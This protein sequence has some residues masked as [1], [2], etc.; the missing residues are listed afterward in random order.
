[1]FL[2]E[3]VKAEQL[4]RVQTENKLT[5]MQKELVDTKESVSIQQQSLKSDLRF[6]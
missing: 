6:D 5:E 2:F 3:S 1:M 4:K